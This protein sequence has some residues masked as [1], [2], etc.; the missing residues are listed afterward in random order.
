MK[1]LVRESLSD[2]DDQ[3]Y[4]DSVTYIL[5]DGRNIEMVEQSFPGMAGEPMTVHIFIDSETGQKLSYR[6]IKNFLNDEDRQEI[7]DVLDDDAESNETS[8]IN[9]VK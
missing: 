6:D 9:W 2:Q 8:A 4:Q 1:K 3:E 7:R 5:T